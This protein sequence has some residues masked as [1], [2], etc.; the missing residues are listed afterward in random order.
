M[1][2]RRPLRTPRVDADVDRSSEPSLK[3]QDYAE[4]VFHIALHTLPELVIFLHKLSW[5]LDKYPKVVSLPRR[6]P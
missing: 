3:G 4:L 1:R 6:R 2:Y 5:Y